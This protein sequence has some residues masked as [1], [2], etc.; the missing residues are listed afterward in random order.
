ME[1]YIACNAERLFD[2][3]SS[4]LPYITFALLFLAIEILIAKTTRTN[5]YKFCREFVL[6]MSADFE[7]VPYLTTRF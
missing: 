3:Q 6:L 4:A 7:A 1:P 2:F 5:H